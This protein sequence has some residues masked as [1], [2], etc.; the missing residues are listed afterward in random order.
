MLNLALL[1][2][3]ATFAP[4]SPAQIVSPQRLTLARIFASPALTGKV[5]RAVQLSPDGK[6]VTVL[7]NRPDDVER[8]DLWAIDPASGRARMLVDSKKVGSGAELSEAERMQRERA[9]LSGL[10][11]IVAYE[12]APDGQHILVPIDGDLYL[13]DLAGNV[14]RLTDTKSPALD[15]AVSEKGRFVSFVRDNRFHVLD[16][17]STIDRA[18]TP[19]GPAATSWGLA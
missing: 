19:A 15:G 13:A 6:L 17:I 1:L 7:R 8:Y 4:S 11:G 3:A 14:R 10:T 2:S 18:I 5:P 9:H 12:W 16:L